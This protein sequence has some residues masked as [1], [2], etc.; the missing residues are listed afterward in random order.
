MKMKETSKDTSSPGQ[1]KR[2][3]ISLDEKD[4]C[5]IDRDN[6]VKDLSIKGVLSIKNTSGSYRIY[7]TYLSVSNR[8]LTDTAEG[9]YPVGE[10]GPEKHWTKDYAVSTDA[11]TLLLRESI[12]TNYN[13]ET[14]GPHRAFYVDKENPTS[15][16]ISVRN[17]LDHDVAKILLKKAMPP[18][19]SDVKA[20]AQSGEVDVSEEDRVIQWTIGGLKPNEDSTLNFKGIV[21]PGTSQPI[22]CGLI[23]VN[24]RVEGGARAGLELALDSLTKSL[25]SANICETASA[26]KWTCEISFSNVSDLVTILDEFTVTGTEGT[27]AR[28]TPGTEVAA[29]TSWTKSIEFDSREMPELEKSIKFKVGH[30]IHKGID[31]HIVKEDDIIPVGQISCSKK[32]DPPEIPAYETFNLNA[33]LTVENLGSAEFDSVKFTDK[34]PKDYK[35]PRPENVKATLRNASIECKVQMEPEDDDHAKEHTLTITVPS[36]LAAKGGLKPKDKLSV[37]Y[38]I[39]AIGA[40]PPSETKYPAPLHVTAFC[41]PPGL[42]TDADTPSDKPPEILV[43][44]LKRV[45]TGATGFESV[46]EGVYEV[47]IQVNNKG[48]A[49]LENI[50]VEHLVPPDFE[51]F[52]Y[53]PKRLVMGEEE[54]TE[55]KKVKFTIPKMNKGAGE[56]I[57]YRVKGR[58]GAEYKQTEARFRVL[59]PKK[60]E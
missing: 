51:F 38:P 7:N 39:T 56:T 49:V 47:T 10:I 19:L 12:D 55:G 33:M 50:L 5:V 46:E 60:T 44:Y 9:R 2:V 13:E 21:R 58:P 3:I 54:A 59:G 25:S 29:G 18:E 11:P 4:D 53:S 20:E 45:L 16:K 35:P 23:E 32:F 22:K 8:G 48:E 37:S 57:T 36:M 28:F 15:F 14:E 41:R 26:G 42:G 43:K 17:N 27:V 40:R 6:N 31:G 52:D 30:E 34:L 24:F 1:E